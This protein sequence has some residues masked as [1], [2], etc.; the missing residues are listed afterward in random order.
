MDILQLILAFFCGVLFTLG[1]YFLSRVL[2][3]IKL[4]NK[5]FYFSLCTLAGA[6]FVFFRLALTFE[7]SMEGMLFFQLGANLSIT[8]AVIFWFFCMLALFEIQKSAGI[9]RAVRWAGYLCLA[10]GLLSFGLELSQASF[11]TKKMGAVAFVFSQKN[12][13]WFYGF[14]SGFFAFCVFYVLFSVVKSVRS[15]RKKSYGVFLVLPLIAAGINDYLL[16]FGQGNGW[17]LTEHIIIVFIILLCY[18][19]ISEDYRNNLRLKA[20]KVVLEKEVQQRTEQLNKINMELWKRNVQMWHDFEMA[21]RIQRSM[22]PQNENFPHQ[23]RVS[24]KGKYQSMAQLGGD[25]YDV[26]PVGEDKLGILMADVSGHGVSSALI[27]SMVKVAFGANARAGFLPSTV[28]QRVNEEMVH[29]IGDLGHYVTA[30]YALFNPQ[31]GEFKYTNAGHHPAL[32]Y[33]AKTKAIKKLKTSGIFIGMFPGVEY[34]YEKITLGTGDRILFYTDGVI[35]V[36]NEQ[37]EFYGIDRLIAFLGRNGFLGADDFLEDLVQEVED[38]SGHGDI[39]DDRALLLLDYQ[40][41]QEGEASGD[42]AP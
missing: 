5:Y 27:T 26:I 2:F 19:F 3:V 36:R 6:L 42:V 34:E 16:I 9:M 8:L 11:A 28:C 23:G 22:L 30:M 1:V 37:K 35:E 29:S 15:L 10:L 25:L 7:G 13:L 32:W 18:D 33:Q 12:P 38:F 14:Q 24:I 17:T 20:M 40:E 21:R 31:S 41:L 4:I 39:N